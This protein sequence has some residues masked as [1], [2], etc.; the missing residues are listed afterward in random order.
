MVR[1]GV[2]ALHASAIA[3]IIVVF[4]PTRAHCD[5]KLMCVHQF[6]RNKGTTNVLAL[7]TSAVFVK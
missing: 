6:M 4:V 5:L 7:R 3:C 2:I 1:D